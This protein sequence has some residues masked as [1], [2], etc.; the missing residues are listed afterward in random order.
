MTTAGKLAPAEPPAISV[1]KPALADRLVEARDDIA[2]QGRERGFV[3][4]E[5][6]LDR[7][8]DEDLSPEQIDEFLS[9]VEEYLRDEGIDVIEIPVEE[10]ERGAIDADRGLPVPTTDPVRLYLKEIARVPLLAAAEEV[11]LAMRIEAG[12]S[13]AFL[14]VPRHASG[15][16]TRREFRRLVDAV[17][18]IRERQLDPDKHL[19]RE[20][21]GQET[22]PGSYQPKDDAEMIQFLRRVQ[23][24]AAVARKRLIEA[25]L[26][27]VV[28]IAKRYVF[29]GMSLMDLA[30]EGN[31][32]LIHAVEKFD[33]VRGY[34]FSTYATWWIRQSV[35]RAV[36]N[37]ARTIRMPVHIS[38][39]MRLLYRTQGRLTQ[40]LGR[41]PSA[42]ELGRQVDM[43]ARKIRELI[44]DSKEPLSMEMPLGDEADA[45]LLG[46][47]VADPSASRAF[48]EAGSD[49]GKRLRDALHTLHPREQRVMILRFGLLDGR[50]QTLEETG[51]EFGLTRERIRQ[52][53]G[54]ALGKL[55]HPSRRD[56]LRG[57]LE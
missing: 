45:Q 33:H 39:A 1:L 48:E 8:L 46:D 28:S 43:P 23:D 35:V 49:L 31:I 7:L 47:V 6:L 34:K 44:H 24:D 15:K 3:S 29:Q 55:R 18:R 11:D 17:V 16:A 30:Q 52:I 26:R 50:P 21:I 19:R 32:G 25:N 36:A 22:I 51:R 9:L 12:R 4:S 2:A 54:K 40:E 37:Q 27:L 38:E 57:Y 42:E 13:A 41:E 10:T 56:S 14:V 53:E 5:D 20:G